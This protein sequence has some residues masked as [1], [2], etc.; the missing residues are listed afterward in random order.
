MSLN[1][2][3]SGNVLEKSALNLVYFVLENGNFC[4]NNLVQNLQ[5]IIIMIIIYKRAMNII[6]IM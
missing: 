2:T 4:V 5:Y 3:K 6:T 1:F